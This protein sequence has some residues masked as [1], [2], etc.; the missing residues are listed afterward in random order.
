MAPS[1]NNDA[2]ART[3]ATHLATEAAT[4]TH[5]AVEA[6]LARLIAEATR[7]AADAARAQQEADRA[8]SALTDVTQDSS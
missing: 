4:S 2:V 3:E 5:H 6:Q 1:T 7:F 8:W